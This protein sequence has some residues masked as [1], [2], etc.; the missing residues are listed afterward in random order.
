[1]YFSVYQHMRE[2][3]STNVLLVHINTV[4]NCMNESVYTN[5]T[6]ILNL[7]ESCSSGLHVVY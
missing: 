3:V 1:M 2:A 5:K 4:F 6:A 7:S